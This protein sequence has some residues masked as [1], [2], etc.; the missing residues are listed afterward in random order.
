MRPCLPPFLHWPDDVLRAA[1][2]L[3][4]LWICTSAGVLLTPET[5][6]EAKTLRTHAG[7]QS[8]LDAETGKIL[9]QR[10]S[11]RQEAVSLLYK[12][13][14]GLS[15]YADTTIRLDT[16]EDFSSGEFYDVR[17][18]TLYG[19][20]QRGLFRTTLGMQTFTWGETFG[21]PITDVVNPIDF[22]Q[23]F[24]SDL[25][26]AKMSV[27]AAS[28]ELITGNF[29]LQALGT[30]FP[31]RSPLP[32]EIEGIEVVQPGDH[33]WGQTFEYGGRIGYLFDLGLDVKVF[34]YAHFSR[35]PRFELRFP[36]AETGPRLVHVESEME[37]VGLSASQAFD[38]IVLRFDGVYENGYLVPVSFK[39]TPLEEAVSLRV[40]AT[41]RAQGTAGLDYTTDSGD[42]YGLQY[43]TDHL[44]DA[45][46]VPKFRAQTLHWAG[47]QVSFSFFS[48][49]LAAGAFVLRGVANSDLWVR[50][51]F[52]LFATDRVKIESEA[53]ILESDGDGNT[54][55]YS[56]RKNLII[57]GSYRF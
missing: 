35:T 47:A 46:S 1:R 10:L 43:Q 50:P 44:L 23:P 2:R 22:T 26:A 4:V 57:G 25:N 31:R 48:D 55:L 15:F 3:S 56:D 13:K 28:L 7:T 24:S 37:T 5:P 8:T 12:K 6:A 30:P 34:Y 17:I 29:Y 39:E 14:Y 33:E 19:E 45:G 38:Q 20:W 42:L 41:E 32:S 54:D 27:A 49:R 18:E 53:N 36:S 21:V 11:I 40:R 52:T 51:K 9:N 16:V